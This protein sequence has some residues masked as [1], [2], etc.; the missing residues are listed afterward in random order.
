M[1]QNQARDEANVVT[2]GA[3]LRPFNDWCGNLRIVFVTGKGGVGKSLI[4]AAIATEQAKL[5]KRVL[6]AE[7]GD[8]SYFKDFWRL[9]SVSYQPMRLD[10]GFDFAL[11]NGETALREY[12]LHYLKVERLFEL[13]FENKVMRSLINVAPGLNEIAILGKITSG[14]RKA[15]PPLNYDLI[16][17]DCYA[18]GHALSLLRTPKGMMNAIQMGPMG[19]QSRDI[20]A[21]LVNPDLVG[22]LAVTLLEEMPVVETIDFSRQLKAELGIAPVVI[23][24]KVL[25]SGLSESDIAELKSHPRGGVSDFV[26]YVEAINSRQ[27][28]FIR[29]LAAA[30]YQAKRIPLIFS[31][32]AD[33]LVE[34]TGEALRHG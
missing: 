28:D 4:S 32:D 23:A 18:T 13:F 21:V 8:T 22:Y 19:N 3:S 16:V 10:R 12:V 31:N 11:W 24:N 29:Q 9:P 26:K 33:R 14:I 6:L 20:E 34:E 1:P 17:V 27:S 30:G 15:G 5:G 25:S 7:I 2:A